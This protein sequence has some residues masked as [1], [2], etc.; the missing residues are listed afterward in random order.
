MHGNLQSAQEFSQYANDV[1][2]Q[3]MMHEAFKGFLGGFRHDAHPM[4]MMC[5]MLGSLAAFYHDNLDL[6][7]PEQR[8][9]AAIR[10]IAKVPTIAAACYR[11][12]IGGPI[13]YPR[14]NLE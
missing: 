8:R 9:M 4:A 10:L 7:D 12:S 11:H 6:D 3:T 13:R 14:N 2:H 5:G 1:T